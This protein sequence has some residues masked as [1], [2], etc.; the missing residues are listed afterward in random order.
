MEWFFINWQYVLHLYIIGA[1]IVGSFNALI[2]FLGMC[3]P[4]HNGLNPIEM[5]LYYVNFACGFILWPAF[6][7]K[8]IGAIIS[9]IL[10]WFRLKRSQ[11][12]RRGFY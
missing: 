12:S 1:I 3:H 9:G 6:A 10:E 4:D 7:I 5:A 8:F 11:R 2:Y